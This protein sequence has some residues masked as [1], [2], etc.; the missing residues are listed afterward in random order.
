MSDDARQLTK[1]IFSANAGV[2]ESRN[3]TVEIFEKV[4]NAVWDDNNI[5][6]KTELNSKQIVAFSR[7]SV[8]AEK[9]DRKL[10]KNL[11]EELCIFAVSKDRK[12]RKEFESVAKASLGAYNQEDVKTIPQRLFGR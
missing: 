1:S 4:S 6:L 9:Y 10:L 5:K 2:E 7:A 8:F 12:S 3:S 11:I